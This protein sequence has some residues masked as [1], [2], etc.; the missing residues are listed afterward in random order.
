ME[1]LLK[2]DQ[3]VLIDGSLASELELLGYNFNVF[4]FFKIDFYDKNIILFTG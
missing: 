3:V 2:D 1:A 4:W